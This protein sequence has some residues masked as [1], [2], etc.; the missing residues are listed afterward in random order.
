MRENPSRRP[1]ATPNG[2]FETAWTGPTSGKAA[3]ERE[4]SALMEAVLRE[5][6]VATSDAEAHRLITCW[7]RAQGP[8]FAFDADNV[9]SL[10]GHILEHRFRGLRFS[11]R[12]LRRLAGW[13][14]EDPS[15]R[16]RLECLWNEASSS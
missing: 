6:V 12:Q 3:D 13:L 4:T 2:S 9:R 11:E 15:A 8:S 14:W 16:A 7:L 5:T 1:D 10:V